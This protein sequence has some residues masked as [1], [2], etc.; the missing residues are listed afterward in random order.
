LKNKS[1]CNRVIGASLEKLGLK[2]KGNTCSVAPPDNK[3]LHG[4][5]HLSNLKINFGYCGGIA[6]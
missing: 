4:K 5:S 1:I 2:K 3:D 6:K